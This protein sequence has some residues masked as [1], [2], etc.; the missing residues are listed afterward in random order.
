MT[1]VAPSLIHLAAATVAFANVQPA[2]AQEAGLDDIVTDFAR[3]VV[4]GDPEV[5]RVL[6]VVDDRLSEHD[7]MQ[8]MASGR[9]GSVMRR[10]QASFIPEL[11]I[12][13]IAAELVRRESPPERPPIRR[14]ASVE[15]VTFDA[16]APGLPT[17]K[18][19]RERALNG[20]VANC[21]VQSEPDAARRW[22][23]AAS[24]RPAVQA[25]VALRPVIDDCTRR[26]RRGGIDPRA[27]A[28]S[29]YRLA[30]IT[31]RQQ[32]GAHN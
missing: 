11:G 3:C 7:A 27:V 15:P 26:F 12:G 14:D 31:P 17:E 21:I 29:H 32:S 4:A 20:Y 25:P 30:N 24:R 19:D 23:V 10:Y 13:A 22:V 28:I 16:V 5:A 1:S 8:R 9:C 18:Y 2:Y 6:V